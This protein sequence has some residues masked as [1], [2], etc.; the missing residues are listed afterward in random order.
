MRA[1]L[2]QDE[3]ERIEALYAVKILNTPPEKA[4]DDIA[5]LAS[6]IAGTPIGL[7]S[8]VDVS[9]QW[10]KARLG[11]D[12]S[13]TSRD[14]A[15]CAH[16]I[17]TPENLLIVPDAER[18]ERFR[19]NPMVVNDPH[20]R[21][22]AGAPLVLS[23]GHAVGT[24]CVLD[25]R[26]RELTAAQEE[27][28]RILSRQ[29][30]GLIEFQLTRDK[31][32]REEQ[33]RA[34]AERD[35]RENAAIL[36]KLSKIQLDFIAD[37]DRFTLFN[38]ILDL[39]L[40]A[41]HSE[42]GFIGEVLYEK[43]TPYLQVHA[44]TDISWTP[45]TRL[46]FES[47]KQSGLQFRN[48]K[49]LF[50]RVMTDRVVVI[51]NSPGT[52]PRRGG[53]PPGHPALNAFLG[54]PLFKGN[55]MVGM[56]GIANRPG[57]YDDKLVEFLESYATSCTYL[58]EGYRNRRFRDEATERWKSTSEKLEMAL[59]G[60]NQNLFE[61][62]LASSELFISGGRDR[63][64]GY[65]VDD[66]G[67]LV[68]TWLKAIHP[69]DLDRVQK[70]AI[71][72]LKGL[73]PF[74]EIEHRARTKTGEW[75][76]I[77]GRGRVTERSAEG[78]ALRLAG[79]YIDVTE[80]HRAADSIRAAY[81]YAENIVENSPEMI[82]SVD[83]AGRVITFNEAAEKTFGYMRAEIL[84][85]PMEILYADA[86]QSKTVRR[87]TTT[88][89]HFRGEVQFRRASGEIFDAWLA[90]ALLRDISGE[91]VG[92]LSLANDI[93]DRK[94][95][96]AMLGDMLLQLEKSNSDL[97][98]ILNRMNVGV[99]MSDEQGRV[100]FFN[101][102][103]RDLLGVGSDAMG[104][105]LNEFLRTNESFNGGLTSRISGDT[106]RGNRKPLNLTAIDGRQL[107]VEVEVQNDPRNP[108]RKILFLYDLTEISNLRRQLEGQSGIADMAGSSP[109]MRLL[110]GEIRALA[111][112]DT[113]VLIQGETGTGKELVARALH[114]LSR[115]SKGPFIAVNCASLSDSLLAG[116]L[117][118][119]KRGAFTGA[120]QDQMGFFEA[121]NGGTI[122]LDEI[123]DIPAAVQVSLLRALQERE[124]IRI[125]ETRARKIDVRIITSTNRD[126]E[127]D[128]A[129]GRFR[130]D[131]YYRLKVGRIQVP[132]L[133]DRLEDLPLLSRLFLD[134][135]GETTGKT[136]SSI[137]ADAMQLLMKYDWPGN[138]R[139]LKNIL[140]FAVLRNPGDVLL[141]ES[142]LSELRV[143]SPRDEGSIDWIADPGKMKKEEIMRAL[144][145]TKG[146]RAAAARLLG[147]GRT[148]LYRQL[149]E[150]MN[151]DKNR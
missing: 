55:Q 37:I 97:Q 73:T 113:T 116:Q 21:F 76:W 27:S 101:Q 74:Y 128:V 106:P 99:V 81:E 70:T 30:V 82:V 133:R 141:A 98:A 126:L 86:S 72:H 49:T 135:I 48:L 39:V 32:D 64:L 50:G 127:K 150:L 23:N 137:D 85:E 89:Q 115:R 54:L 139:E 42:Y 52:D 103:C 78:K 144:R 3:A 132:A 34:A 18:D 87:T 67:P 90:T 112:S 51:S 4:Y 96:E 40:A 63:V 136:I 60:A 140:E 111:Q 35:V 91:V 65:S 143:N 46:L 71:E 24:L 36:A 8:F 28:L 47:V 12:I 102:H 68:K 11:L 7:I 17:L 66:M 108:R 6:L 9:R 19:D 105:P 13:E 109:P 16:T 26:P 119:H 100:S 29:I 75:K 41:T 151:E 58:I 117:F 5:R 57:G 138:V 121:A 77:L 129:A 83:S 114:A 33:K 120:L 124:V 146:N 92:E 62:N 110:F 38:E 53:L 2:P 31:L 107:Y 80:R 118:G 79:T 123:G 88:K 142:I 134:R 44:I 95:A 94:R 22:Y 147:I 145:E 20:V 122:L 104:L 84:G 43:S 1:E 148:T 61:L 69:E 10:F 14:E 15:F 93:S 56:I 25:Y 59:E 131:L 130:Q 45:E 149:E 125:G